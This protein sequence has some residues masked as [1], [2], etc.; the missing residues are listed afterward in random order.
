MTLVARTDM[1][2]TTAAANRENIRSTYEYAQSISKYHI[3]GQTS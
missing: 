3:L 1:L 2:V